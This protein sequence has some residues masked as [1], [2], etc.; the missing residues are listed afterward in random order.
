MDIDPIL[1]KKYRIFHPYAFDRQL[2]AYQN[3]DTRFVHYTDANAVFSILENQNIWM[4]NV[5]CMN[6]YLEVQYGLDCLANSYTGPLGTQMKEFLN[7]LHDDFSEEL[8]DLFDGWSPTFFRQT[9]LFSI[10]EHDAQENEYGRLSMWRAYSSGTGIAFVLKAQP[11]FQPSDALRAYTSPVAYLEQVEFDHEFSR[12]L[13]NLKNNEDFI[14]GMSRRELMGRMFNSFKDAVLNTKHPGFKEE[15]EWRV[16]YNH[17]LEKSDRLEKDVKVIGGN[18]QIIYKIPLKNSPEDNLHHM[19]IGEVLDRV[20]IG[21]TEY[22]EA[23][24]AA[25]ID[26]LANL[27]IEDAETMVTVSNIPLR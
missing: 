7:S 18:P 25:L 10:S 15:R 21:P 17:E 11:F 27:G 24:Q 23:A 20:I 16:I 13:Q 5:S 2:S 4:R 22:P 9:F 6:D 8:E 14:Q 3:P 12:V 1:L 19:E 26:H